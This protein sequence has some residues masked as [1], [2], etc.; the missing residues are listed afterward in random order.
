LLARGSAP[1]QVLELMSAELTRLR[2]RHFAQHQVPR[3]RR[4]G[5]ATRNRPSQRAADEPG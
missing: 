5:F 4:R 1:H 2:V 3:Q